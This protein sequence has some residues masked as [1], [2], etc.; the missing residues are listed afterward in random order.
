MRFYFVERKVVAT[1]K[2]IEYQNVINMI[3]TFQLFVF[4]F[5]I[6]FNN[7]KGILLTTEF[8]NVGISTSSNQKLVGLNHNRETFFH[9]NSK[10]F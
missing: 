6:Y 10:P 1:I 5:S 9:L 4:N 7:I 2:N 8:N 3:D